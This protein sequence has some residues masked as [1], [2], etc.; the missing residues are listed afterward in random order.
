MYNEKIV[1]KVRFYAHMLT[2]EKLSHVALTF[3]HK[4]LFSFFHQCELIM[5][6][7]YILAKMTDKAVI[8]SAFLLAAGSCWPVPTCQ[9]RIRP[10]LLA[11]SYVH[12]I[13]QLSSAVLT[14]ICDLARDICCLARALLIDERSSLRPFYCITTTRV[15]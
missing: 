1:L 13:H 14:A 12:V 7:H 10:R 5:E 3:A 11:N 4:D 6:L 2:R 9:G 8:L 15:L